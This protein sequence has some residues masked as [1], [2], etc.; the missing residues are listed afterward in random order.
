[1]K[2]TIVFAL[3]LLLLIGCRHNRAV[4]TRLVELDSLISVAPDSAAALLETIP[5]DSLRDA[6]NRAYH[7]LLITQARYKA[8]IPATSDSAINIALAH[9]SEG[10]DYDR[11]IRSLIYKGCVM[12]ELNQPD[13]A[14]Y[15]FKTAEAA[16]SSDDHANLG[17]ILFRI[18]D[19][20]QYE[21]VATNLAMTYYQ[22]A[23]PH[24]K[25]SGQA[26]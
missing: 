15:W 19:L 22:R 17:Y 16:A 11:L 20:Y 6:E 12:T 21:F 23:L 3:A 1:M 4:S 8:Y 26:F 9:Y 18:G 2:K 14:V 25:K 10:G 5:S 7:A 24:L 13:S